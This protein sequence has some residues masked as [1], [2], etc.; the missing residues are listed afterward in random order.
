MRIFLGWV[1]GFA[2]IDLLG[3]GILHC[4]IN[5]QRSLKENLGG[6][7]LTQWRIHIFRIIRLLIFL[8]I[9]WL[10]PCILNLWI[11]WTI[12]FVVSILYECYLKK[13]RQPLYE[14]YEKSGS[15]D[16]EL[17]LESKTSQKAGRR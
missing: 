4:T 8:A 5:K 11:S 15:E 17:G 16:T 13:Q 6:Y 7:Y 12:I 9:F 3:G 1:W 14:K 2:A 10:Y